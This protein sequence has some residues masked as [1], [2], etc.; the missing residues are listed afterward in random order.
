MFIANIDTILMI[1]TIVLLFVFVVAAILT[2]VVALEWA[3][4]EHRERR[5]HKQALARG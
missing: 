5:Q 4:E 3:D 2:L 1:S